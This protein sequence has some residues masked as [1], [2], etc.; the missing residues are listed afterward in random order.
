M[1]VALLAPNDQVAGVMR[2]L[3]TEMGGTWNG[4]VREG[5]VPPGAR[6]LHTHESRAARRDRARHQQV[7]QQ[8]DGAPAVS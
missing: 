2:Q 8:R 7:L 4:T 1:N 5:L 6:L 3:W